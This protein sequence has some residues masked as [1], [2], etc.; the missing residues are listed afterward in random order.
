MLPSRNTDTVTTT[1]V[2]AITK[3]VRVTPSCSTPNALLWAARTA[4]T[5]R[6]RRRARLHP[7]VGT[8]GGA[9]ARLASLPRPVSGHHVK[10]LNRSIHPD[11]GSLRGAL[12][13]GEYL[14]YPIP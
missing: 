9:A 6:A 13:H 14:V 2:P 7:G 3:S 11:I 4:P 12:R 8:D 1:G 10:R 5:R